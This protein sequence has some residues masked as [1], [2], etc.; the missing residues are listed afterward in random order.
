MATDS[1]SDVALDCELE[2]LLLKKKIKYSGNTSNMRFHLQCCHLT[3]ISKL[4]TPS[5]NIKQ[6][7]TESKKLSLESHMSMPRN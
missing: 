5:T 4:Q 3:A 7:S 6:K 1:T 2:V